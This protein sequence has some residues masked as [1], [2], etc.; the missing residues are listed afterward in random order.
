MSEF[1]SAA[2]ESVAARL[3][4]ATQPRHAIAQL[5][6]ELGLSDALLATCRPSLG[7]LDLLQVPRNDTHVALLV[8]LRQ[9]LLQ[10]IAQLDERAVQTMLTRT[11]A[12]VAMAELRDVVLAL[13]A[14]ANAIPAPYLETLANTTCV[15]RLRPSVSRSLAAVV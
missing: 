14:R 11:F 3:A 8:R 9:T 6:R 2:R 13:L 10:R 1:G 15:L 4:A 5:Q 7:L 12:Y